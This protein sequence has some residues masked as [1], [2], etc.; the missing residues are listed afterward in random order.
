MVSNRYVLEQRLG[1]GGYGDVYRAYDKKLER[2]V[3][4]KLF[5][6][7][8]DKARLIAEARAVAALSHPNVVGVFEVDDAADPPFM[9]MEL[10]DG[11]TLRARMGNATIPNKRGWLEQIA[12]A[13]AAAHRAGFIHRDVK[14][15]NVLITNVGDVAKVLDFG[16]AK[17]LAPPP[18]VL[19]G[20]TR[21]EPPMTQDG[22]V[23]GTLHYMA[24]ER[25][26]GHAPGPHVDQ[27]AWG[28]VAYELLAGVHP[29]TAAAAASIHQWILSGDVPPLAAG[30][31]LPPHLA[32]TVMR[33][34]SREVH[35][36]FASMDDLHAALM[37][38]GSDPAIAMTRLSRPLPE[39]AA[40][41]G[42][43]LPAAPTMIS[44]MEPS[45]A[46]APPQQRHPAAPARPR[47]APPPRPRPPPQ[48]S[49]RNY[50]REAVPVLL[51]GVAGLF[52][53]P[54]GIAGLVVGINAWRR[55]L[56][57]GS[58]PA[59]MLMLGVVLSAISSFVSSVI[60]VVFLLLA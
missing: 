60:V 13:L 11:Q 49:T 24:L 25:L 6:D 38:G 54:L 27:W 42:P 4:L 57:E 43:T 36:R 46:V 45:P 23:T 17:R 29:S 21:I 47:P 5:T 55:T 48:V 8:G 44:G 37:Q 1:Q 34:L 40:S 10:V 50:E 16:I 41:P 32:A 14:P 33:A 59:P 53:V 28:V 3:A 26:L 58:S 18:S 30:D 19:D 35:A 56:H 22:R 51:M 31:A 12:S 2:R 20:E 52:C 9:V 7:G 15:E 39:A